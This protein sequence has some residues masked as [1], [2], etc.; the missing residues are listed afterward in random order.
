MTGGNEV[1][2]DDPS[3]QGAVKP[4]GDIHV[5]AVAGIEDHQID[6][7]QAGGRLA[8]R[9]G[10]A[11]VKLQR[12]DAVAT[13]CQQPLAIATTT[14]HLPAGPPIIERQLKADARG[15]TGYQHPAAAHA[16]SLPLMVRTRGPISGNCS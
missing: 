3:K 2:L 4:L 10:I 12:R 13:Q 8:H 6:P 9:T 15:S 11:P 7:R 5:L 16:P 1:G 14:P